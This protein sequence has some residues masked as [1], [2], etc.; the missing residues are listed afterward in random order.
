MKSVQKKLYLKRGR[1]EVAPSFF[2][3]FNDSF[4]T[5][6]GASLRLAFY[7]ADTLALA[8]RLAYVANYLNDDVRIARTNFNAA[9]YYSEPIAY[10]M[11]DLEWSL[12][13][14]KIAVYNSIRHFD[15]YILVGVGGVWSKTS[16]SAEISVSGLKP[17]F[18]LGVGLRFIVVDWAAVNVAIINTTYLDVPTGTSYSIVQNITAF[19]IGFSFFFPLRSTYREVE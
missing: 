12:F 19:N 1:F 6:L 5:H 8:L 9:V 10:G 17:G 2:V 18:D 3:N 14:G 7:P 13:Y 11:V 15:G 16:G 4:F